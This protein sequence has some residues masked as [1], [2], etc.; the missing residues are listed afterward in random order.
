MKIRIYATLV[1]LSGLLGVSAQ[2]IH[3]SQFYGVPVNLNPALTGRFDGFW[4]ASA[5]YREQWFGMG[6]FQGPRVFPFYR[7]IG[8]NADFNLLRDR[9]DNMGLGAGLDFNVDQSNNSKIS[10]YTINAALA[11]QAEF[12]SRKQFQIGVGLK[13][14][15]S[16]KTLK[17]DFKFASG[18]TYDFSSQ[19]YVYQP[20][21][22]SELFSTDNRILGNFAGG[23]YFNYEFLKG[24]SVNVG[25]SLNNAIQ[26]KENFLEGSVNADNTRLPMRHV[27]HGG[28]QFD[29][30]RFTI[31]PGFQYQN[32]AKAMEAVF[33]V[34]AGYHINPD[35]AKKATFFLGCWY[36]YNDAV[37]PK[38]AFEWKGFRIG[39]AYDIGVSQLAR[40]VRS[41]RDGSPGIQGNAPMAFEINVV[42]IG[43]LVIPKENNYLFNPRF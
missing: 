12:G 40:D 23:V 17:N 11:Y 31:Q 2:D 41:A 39:A 27:V 32:Q 33:G 26:P 35:P 30:K 14:G 18:Y 20:G 15:I 37:I 24:M 7:T 19:S 13:G 29:V 4:R 25:Y 8:V 34:N 5:I 28:F 6:Q 10:S 38:A 16:F 42:Y 1:F 22:A 3:F 36:R 9:L 43:K 21:N